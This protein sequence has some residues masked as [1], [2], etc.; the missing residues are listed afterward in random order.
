MN[1]VK[2]LLAGALTV[3]IIGLAIGLAIGLES[4]VAQEA[5]AELPVASDASVFVFNTTLFLISGMVVMFMAA[6]FCMLEVG[7][8]RSKNAATI[9]VKNIALYSIAGIMVWLT[10]YNLI[11]GIAE[12][13]YIGTFGFWGADDSLS[14]IHISEPTRPY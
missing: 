3:P 9:C 8:V 1:V 5:A 7:L 4:A 13:G 10:G 11:Y 12:G 14:L 6:G 2:K